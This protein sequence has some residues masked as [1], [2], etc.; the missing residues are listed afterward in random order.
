MSYCDV[1]LSS[2]SNSPHQASEMTKCVMDFDWF[3]QRDHSW[4]LPSSRMLMKLSARSF[5]FL[6]L[7]TPGGW[8]IWDKPV[9]KKSVFFSVSAVAGQDV[10]EVVDLVFIEHG[11]LSG[12]LGALNRVVNLISIHPCRRRVGSLVLQCCVHLLSLPPFPAPL[13]PLLLCFVS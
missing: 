10:E 9:K 2:R 4:F 12:A 7:K 8:R 3:T 1:S 11:H 5:F 6:H 13:F